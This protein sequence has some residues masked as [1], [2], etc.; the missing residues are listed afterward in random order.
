MPYTNVVPAYGRDY[1]SQKEVQADWDA[2]KDFRVE[3]YYSPKHGSYLNKID[4]DK[5]IPD[6]TITVRY[7]NQRKVYTVK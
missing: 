5:F 6:H 1:K 4:K 7:D 2:N 3:D